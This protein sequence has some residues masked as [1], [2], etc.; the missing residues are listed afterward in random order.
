MLNTAFK[1]CLKVKEYT[2]ALR[3][4]LRIDKPGKVEEVLA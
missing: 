3:I 4:A 2:N 1:I